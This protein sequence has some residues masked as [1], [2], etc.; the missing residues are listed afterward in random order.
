MIDK[1]LSVWESNPA[2]ARVTLTE[3]HTQTNHLEL[4]RE[5]FKAAQLWPLQFRVK[6]SVMSSFPLQY[7]TL[8]E[9]YCKSKKKTPMI[10]PLSLAL[11][12]KLQI[13]DS[14]THTL[15]LGVEPSFRAHQAL[16]HYRPAMTGA[17]TDQYTNKD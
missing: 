11:Y 16:Y 6:V 14:F 5:K 7:Y 9:V 13:Q 15:C 10:A 2:F 12:E 17:C 4:D 8:V 1:S 3:I